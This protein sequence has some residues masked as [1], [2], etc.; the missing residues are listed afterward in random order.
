MVGGGAGKVVHRAARHGFNGAQIE[1]AWAIAE[2][3]GD[4]DA[5]RIERQVECDLE[6]Y[7]QMRA[8]DLMPVRLEIVDQALAESEFFAQRLF[9]AGGKNTLGGGEVLVIV[10]AAAWR[11]RVVAAIVTVTVIGRAGRAIN[12]AALDEPLMQAEVALLADRD[13]NAGALA[14]FFGVGREAVDDRIDFGAALLELVAFGG[15]LFG[16]D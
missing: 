9:D 15:E 10:I 13:D 8:G 3:V 4:I 14:V 2:V 1:G 6:I 5:E 16:E 11:K 12:G 7:R